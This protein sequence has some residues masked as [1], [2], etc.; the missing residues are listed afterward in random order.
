MTKFGSCL[1][2]HN[3]IKQQRIT[4]KCEVFAKEYKTPEQVMQ[5]RLICH[6]GGIIV[7]VV[8]INQH[9]KAMGKYTSNL[10]MKEL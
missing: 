2:R 9:I 4:F 10:N 3:R 1:G 5:H 8:I 6:E 7:T